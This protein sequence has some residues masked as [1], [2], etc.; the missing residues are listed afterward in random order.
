M[1]C[2]VLSPWCSQLCRKSSSLFTFCYVSPWCSELCR[3]VKWPGIVCHRS[4]FWLDSGFSNSLH[5]Q[6]PSRI[7]PAPPDWKR[8]D[9][10]L[11]RDPSSFPLR[12][13]LVIRSQQGRLLTTI[14]LIV[15]YYRPKNSF[16][17]KHSTTAGYQFKGGWF[18]KYILFV[19]KLQSARR[20]R[21]IGWGAQVHVF[22]LTSFAAE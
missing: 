9:V 16:Y 12:L 17:N 13:F 10:R 5:G 21:R 8:H 20:V 11:T 4:C 19:F 7:L 2:H 1:L 18:R 3:K 22:K 14:I 15:I 6:S